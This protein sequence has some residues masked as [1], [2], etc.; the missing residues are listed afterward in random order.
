MKTRLPLRF[1]A[2]SWR[3]LFSRFSRQKPKE[4]E[5]PIEQ[6]QPKPEPLD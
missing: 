1:F 2:S 4:P 5:K 6:E 3:D